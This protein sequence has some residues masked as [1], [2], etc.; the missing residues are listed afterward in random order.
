MQ[1]FNVVVWFGEQYIYDQRNVDAAEAVAHARNLTESVGAKCGIVTKVMIT[2][3][4]DY[5]NFLW[6]HGKG[7]VFPTKEECDEALE[8]RPA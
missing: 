2:D 7:V 1:G 4:D 8:N 5:C 6:E 3:G